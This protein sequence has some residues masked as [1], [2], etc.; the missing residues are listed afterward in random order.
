ML[1]SADELKFCTPPESPIASDE[2]I[3][4]SRSALP[5]V[6]TG[7]QMEE[8]DESSLASAT[9]QLKREFTSL[10]TSVRLSLE[11]QRV[12]LES[13][14]SHLKT[15]EAMAIDSEFG[16]A[17]PLT[18][19]IQ[20]LA[21]LFPAIAPYC[22]W[23][24]HLLVEN[25]VIT[26][27]EDDEKLLEKLEKYKDKFKRYCEARLCKCPLDQFGADHT[28]T[29][30]T[31]V[32]MKIDQEWRTVKLKQII[33]VLDNVASILKIKPHQL[34]L[35][36]IQ[37]GCIEVTFHIP[38]FVATKCLP[39]SSEQIAALQNVG[40]IYI[41]YTM[42]WALAT[43]GLA[44]IKDFK[45]EAAMK[46]GLRETEMELEVREK[47]AKLAEKDIHIHQLKQELE[48]ERV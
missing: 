8:L 22:S 11:R 37:K 23:F 12:S 42:R 34:H 35:Q 31:P 27:C 47:T 14:L 16:I 19:P 21:E 33:M 10:F 5:S 41:Q 48:H 17:Q 1:H 7:S 40:V 26:F 39:P 15:F 46:R 29:D 6:T 24:N 32:V 38:K 44:S 13:V 30:T 9:R 3:F 28:S 4:E 18:N 36:T 43:G 20:S 25:I 45:G 2:D